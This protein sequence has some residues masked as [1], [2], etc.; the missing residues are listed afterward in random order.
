[1]Y[2][3]VQPTGPQRNIFSLVLNSRVAPEVLAKI[4]ERLRALEEVIAE[5]CANDPGPTPDDQFLSLT[6]CLAPIRGRRVDPT[7]PEGEAS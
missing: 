1:M 3:D 2:E 5:E 4:N 7:K 6:I